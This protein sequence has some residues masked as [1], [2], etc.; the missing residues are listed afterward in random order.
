VENALWEEEAE[1][2]PFDPKQFLDRDE[3]RGRFLDLMEFRDDRRLLAIRAQGGAGKTG[4]LRWCEWKCKFP[5]EGSA[6]RP[7]SRV[8]LDQI[9]GGRV[10][11]LVDQIKNDL[12]MLEW[13]TFEVIRRRWLLYDLNLVAEG[14]GRNLIDNRGANISGSPTFAGQ[15]FEVQSENFY[16]LS[17]RGW[18]S[19]QHEDQANKAYVEAFC[20]DL[21]RNA[22][23]RHVVLIFDSYDKAPGKLREWVETFIHTHCLEREGRPS[24]LAVVLAGRW[25]PP[26]FKAKLREQFEEFIELI[27]TFE[28]W[29]E[30]LVGE[31]LK[32]K[33]FPDATPGEIALLREKINGGFPLQNVQSAML[34][35]RRLAQLG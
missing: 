24:Q 4:L 16:V 6:P 18:P 30:E 29:S 23:E 13:S 28:E 19:K 22:D 8:P 34:A 17:G 3:A 11:D 9:E 7:V 15:Y 1:H 27:E 5:D 35:I 20:A 2:G 33:G 10:I 26:S 12:S 14:F 32:I 25:L 21:R 31:F